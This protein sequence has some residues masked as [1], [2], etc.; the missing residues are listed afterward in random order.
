MSEQVSHSA[1]NILS[2][3]VVDGATAIALGKS[4]DFFFPRFTDRSPLMVA[5]ET[6]AQMALLTLLS[7]Q[8]GTALGNQVDPTN[9][10]A[11]VVPAYFS[12]PHLSANINLLSDAIGD[13]F[14]GPVPTK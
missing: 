4:I 3:V 10:L 14:K 1:L 8:I 5:L 9:G 6:A 11:F 12:S 2:H 13:L 7:Q